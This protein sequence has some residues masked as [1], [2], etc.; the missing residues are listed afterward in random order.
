V[1][2]RERGRPLN[3]Q[4]AAKGYPGP[5]EMAGPESDDGYGGDQLP[6]TTLAAFS[7]F[8]PCWHSNSTASPSLSV[9]YPV[10]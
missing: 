10:S 9:L 5:S 3:E 8:G 6:R 1:F 7:P 4:E 2:L